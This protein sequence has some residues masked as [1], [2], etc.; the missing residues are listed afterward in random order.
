MPEVH[1]IVFRSSPSPLT[2]DRRM[3]FVQKVAN[4]VRRIE[5]DEKLLNKW[6]ELW[7][8]VKN[9]VD[10]VLRKDLQSIDKFA[11]RL[12]K[13][14]LTV[15]P[16]IFAHFVPARDALTINIWGVFFYP[17]Y[18]LAGALIHEEDHKCFF[19]ERNM[20]FAPEEKQ[21]E[22]DKQH[23]VEMELRAVKKEL[24]FAKRIKP[25]IGLGWHVDFLPQDI[26]LPHPR[27]S[28]KLED[29]IRLKE[30]LIE[31]FSERRGVTID[32]NRRRQEA[33]FAGLANIMETLGISVDAASLGKTYERISVPF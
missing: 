20:L 33:G 16:R 23:G 6:A 9:E 25:L 27:F 18:E 11:K 13:I 32:Y 4:D 21:K 3:V 26:N 2:V 29:Y 8:E 14:E 24:D 30:R 19:E 22:F 12:P 15:D 5:K 1:D 7:S 28:Y 17:P 10:A 31:Q